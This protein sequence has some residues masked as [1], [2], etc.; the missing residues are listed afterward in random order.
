MERV[1]IYLLVYLLKIRKHLG[2]KNYIYNRLR[3]STVD[4][5][6]YE[7][8]M[9]DELKELKLIELSQQTIQ[10]QF[11]TGDGYIAQLD[12]PVMFLLYAR[13]KYIFFEILFE[14]LKWVFAAFV[15]GLISRL[16]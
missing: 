16:M 6:T 5:A 2:E 12:M 4:V 8:N 13:G 10:M 9:L 7:Q 3:N 14:S 1:P 11:N 15:G